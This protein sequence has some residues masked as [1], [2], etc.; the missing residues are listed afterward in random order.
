MKKLQQRSGAQSRT[1]AFALAL[2]LALLFPAPVLANAGAHVHEAV[3][4]YI[5]ANMPWP[6][7]T[8]RLDFISPEP[9]IPTR[10]K[11]ITLRIESAGNA[12]FIGDTAF[13]VRLSADGNFIRTETIR[14]RIEVLRDIVVAARTI[15]SG[16]IL[17]E[18]DIRLAK[19]WVRRNMPDALSSL[20]DAI[21]KRITAP[22]GPGTELSAARLKDAPLVRK[23]KMVRVQFDNGSLRITTVGIP[24]EDGTAGSMVRIR[25]V[26]S[27]KV[28]YARVLGDSLVGVDI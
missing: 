8:V 26:T 11:E 24:E 22:A 23:G 10:G 7:G 21:G 2:M 14:T 20:E 25:N 16:A 18:Q 15:R 27:N 9:D 19:K 28:I 13:L 3:R 6:Q 12:D 17:T 4:E 5:E 1:A